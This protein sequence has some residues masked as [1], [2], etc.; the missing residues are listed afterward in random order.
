[1]A[2][3]TETR[4]FPTLDFANGLMTLAG[5]NK[6]IE[7]L[8]LEGEVLVKNVRNSPNVHIQAVLVVPETKN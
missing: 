1:M 5:W 8:Q 3:I 2:A 6:V 4:A 7:I